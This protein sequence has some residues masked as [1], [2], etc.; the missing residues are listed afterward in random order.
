MMAVMDLN[1]LKKPLDAKLIGKNQA[2][3]LVSTDS[4]EHQPRALF[5]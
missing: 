2:F 5:T 3:A 1:E 4:R